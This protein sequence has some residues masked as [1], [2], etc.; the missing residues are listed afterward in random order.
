MENGILSRVAG[1]LGRASSWISTNEDW[2]MRYG[3]RI[4]AYLLFAGAALMILHVFEII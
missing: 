4:A 1:W 3:T 2:I